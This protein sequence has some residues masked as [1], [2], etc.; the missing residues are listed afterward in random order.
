MQ[1][2]AL[3]GPTVDGEFPSERDARLAELLDEALADAVAERRASVATGAP[4][5][6]AW[7]LRGRVVDDRGEPVAGATIGWWSDSDA[8]PIGGEFVSFVSAELTAFASREP[9]ANAPAIPVSAA[10]GRFVVEG[11]PAA[12]QVGVVATLSPQRWT[13]ATFAVDGGEV[14]IVLPRLGSIA[15][16]VRVAPGVDPRELFVGVEPEASRS[17]AAVASYPSFECQSRVGV[18]LSGSFAL[19]DVPVGRWSLRVDHRGRGLHARL[20]EVDGVASVVEEAPPDPR[21]DPLDL[22]AALRTVTV[23]VV[24]ADGARVDA[25]WWLLA[26]TPVGQLIGDPAADRERAVDSIPSPPSQPFTEGRFALTV[27][28]TWRPRVHVAV[29]GHRIAAAELSGAVARVVVGAPI[30][31][32]VAL[33]PELRE[34][35]RLAPASLTMAGCESWSAEEFCAVEARFDDEG[36]AQLL[37]PWVG[38]LKPRAFMRASHDAELSSWIAL[39]PFEV[40]ESIG[41]EWIELRRAR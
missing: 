16:R 28:S 41:H 36:R 20:A 3:F 15:G 35:A 12:S 23:E 18:D 19:R 27:P 2:A 17:R 13:S 29:P 34:L 32:H 22:S 25:G 38:W 30:V 26:R 8:R 1:G 33:D 21:L 7:T 4:P 11:L 10:D 5:G 31:L 40:G 39:E 9:T 37:V 6:A 24:A 14:R